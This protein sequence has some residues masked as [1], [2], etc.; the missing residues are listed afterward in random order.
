MIF[1]L[2][3]VLDFFYVLLLMHFLNPDHNQEITTIIKSLSDNM[4]QSKKTKNPNL[5]RF[6]Y[7]WG[8]QY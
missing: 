4:K 5:K 2:L 1:F 3:I 8:T 7:W 6:N